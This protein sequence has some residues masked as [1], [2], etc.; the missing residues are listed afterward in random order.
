MRITIVA[1]AIVVVAIAAKAEPEPQFPVAAGV[2][3]NPYYQLYPS[4][5]VNRQQANPAGRFLF[6]IDWDDFI[7]QDV[8]TLWR[9]RRVWVTCTAKVH[10][11]CRDRDDDDDDDNNSNDSDDD[12]KRKPQRKPQR[13]PS[14]K[15]KREVDETSQFIAPSAVNEVEATVAPV[16]NV[17]EPRADSDSKP[18]DVPAIGSSQYLQPLPFGL[19]FSRSFVRDWEL[20]KERTVIRT[21]IRV[22][23]R[24]IVP[25]CSAAS[26]FA[27]CPQILHHGSEHD[28]DNWNHDNDDWDDDRFNDSGALDDDDLDLDDAKK[29]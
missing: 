18:Y 10:R 6:G 7:K 29:L 5:P 26:N 2:Q 20:H 9:T 22:R 27:Q 11:R 15:P 28:D 1:L 13:K 25:R 12:L 19:P 4:Y 21:K 16:M 8:K 23:T 24:T 3:P 14:S 17:R